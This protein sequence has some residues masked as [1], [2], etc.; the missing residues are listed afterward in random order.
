M[1]L[2]E[3]LNSKGC[4]MKEGGCCD[5]PQ[6]AE[7]LAELIKRPGVFNVMEIGFNAGSSADVFLKNNKN[8]KLTSFDIG[9][10]QYSRVAKEYIDAAYPGRHTLVI[11]DST[12]T[13]PEFICDVK[14]DII[15]IDGGHEYEVA[16][17]DVANCHRLAHENTILVVDDT[18]FKDGWWD[19][20]TIG[21][22]KVWLEIKNKIKLLNCLDMSIA[23]GVECQWV[24]T[25]LRNKKQNKYNVC[26]NFKTHV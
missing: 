24:V 8:I 20:W 12:Q 14:F 4:E 21:P 1:S 16:K 18:L 11:G 22:T 2:S 19:L 10:H 7:D 17:A 9:E 26:K 23:R 3:F 25:C 13:I 15:F 6:Q 5:V